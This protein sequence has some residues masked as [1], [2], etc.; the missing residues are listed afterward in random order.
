MPHS[1]PIE[2]KFVVKEWS[3]PNRCIEGLLWIIWSKVT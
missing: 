3:R 1:A 2:L